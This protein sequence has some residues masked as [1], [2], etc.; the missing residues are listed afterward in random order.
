MLR[1]KLSHTKKYPDIGSITN[2]IYSQ[3]L[4][5]RDMDTPL[6]IMRIE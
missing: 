4:K 6:D 1:Y 2:A 5:R 3:Y